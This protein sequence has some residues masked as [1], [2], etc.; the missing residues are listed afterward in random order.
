MGVMSVKLVKESVVYIPSPSPR[1]EFDTSS[2]ISPS[3]HGSSTTFADR[4][5]RLRREGIIISGISYTKTHTTIRGILETEMTE[6]RSLVRLVGSVGS[7]GTL[8]E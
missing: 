4:G 2:F 5:D 1:A 7:V 8:K 6:V 3:G